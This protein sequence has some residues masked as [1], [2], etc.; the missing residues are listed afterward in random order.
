MRGDLDQ[1]PEKFQHLISKQ[2]MNLTQEPK[3]FSKKSR[4]LFLTLQKV[5]NCNDG[6]C[7]L[8]GSE[9]TEGSKE[10]RTFQQ[11]VIVEVILRSL[12]VKGKKRDEIEARE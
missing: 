10:M 5:Y 3:R 7:G 11:V 1:I 9:E 8:H 12:A 6:D 4:Q 2:K